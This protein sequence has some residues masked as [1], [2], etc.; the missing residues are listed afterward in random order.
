VTNRKRLQWKMAKTP[1]AEGLQFSLNVRRGGGK[2]RSKKGKGGRQRCLKG[3]TKQR[4]RGGG[5]KMNQGRKGE[6]QMVWSR[7]WY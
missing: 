4:G 1:K 5:T 2:K 3:E 7:Y 6:N